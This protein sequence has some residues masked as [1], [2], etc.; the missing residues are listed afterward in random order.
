MKTILLVTVSCVFF[1]TLLLGAGRPSAPNVAAQAACPPGEEPLEVVPLA[2]VLLLTPASQGA[3][4]VLTRITL[5][6]GASLDISPTAPT[7]FHVESGVLRY[8]I[9]PG[10]SI[11]SSPQCTSLDGRFAGGGTTEV[12]ADGMVSVNQGETLIADVVPTGP[13]NNGGESPLVVLQVALVPGEIDPTTG[14]PILDPATAGRAKAIERQN[15][16]D[17]CRTESTSTGDALA[18]ASTGS[19]PAT[20]KSGDAWAVDSNESASKQEPPKGCR[21]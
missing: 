4:M 17:A 1:G 19:R 18:E 15:R 9:Q 14:N 13:I 10:L 7:A 3:R 12:D 6:P 21:R 8:Q 16:R 11:T 2:E 5:A 20:P